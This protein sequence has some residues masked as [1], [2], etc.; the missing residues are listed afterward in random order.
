MHSLIP[1]IKERN[2]AF[3]EHGDSWFIVEYSKD[4][5]KGCSAM[6]KQTFTTLLKLDLSIKTYVP[7]LAQMCTPISSS[8][9]FMVY[10]QTPPTVYSAVLCREASC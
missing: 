5:F 2:C 3:T 10:E 1:P 4:I 6:L 9:V 7:Y 8:K